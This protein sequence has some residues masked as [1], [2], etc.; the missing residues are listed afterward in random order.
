MAELVDALDLGSSE[1]ARAGS[2]PVP[3]INSF[4]RIMINELKV[5]LTGIG[6]SEEQATKAIETVADFSKSKLPAQMHPML[7][8]VMDGKT[9]DLGALG[10]LLGGFKNPFGK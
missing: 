4:S 10:G 9:P 8:E 1:L 7:D 3:G 2:I 6:L 5:R